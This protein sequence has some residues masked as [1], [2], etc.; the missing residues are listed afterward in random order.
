MAQLLNVNPTRQE[1][2]KLKRKRK[3]AV[4]GH[5]LLK[6]KRDGLMKQFMAII[7]EA[8]ELRGNMEETLGEAF[9]SFVFASAVMRSDAMEE[10]LSMPAK[11]VTLQ[12][13]TKN[14]MSV[15]IPQFEYK[16]EGGFLSY[17]LGTTAS[18]LDDSLNTFNDALKGMVKLAEIEH[19]A[20]LLAEEI[21]KTR[22]RVNALEYVFIPQIVDTIKYIQ[23]KLNEQE[24]GTIVTMMKVKDILNQ[25]E[26]KEKEAKQAA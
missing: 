13:E 11:K 12:S 16:E 26:Q 17:S 19:S 1:L 25:Q 23:A 3:M 2:L 14:V 10:A 8:K 22:R 9:K 7:R 4:R 15:N 6:E 18:D 21:E 24:R 20:K 5:K